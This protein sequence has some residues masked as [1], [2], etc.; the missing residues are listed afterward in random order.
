MLEEKIFVLHGYV[1]T[2]TMAAFENLACCY[3]G[4]AHFWI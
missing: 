3:T 2:H 4:I 1:H